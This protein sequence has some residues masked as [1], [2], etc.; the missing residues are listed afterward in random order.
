MA[1][2]QTVLYCRNYWFEINLCNY[3]LCHKVRIKWPINT[4]EQTRWHC[5]GHMI[6]VTLRRARLVLRWA[7]IHSCN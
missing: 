6:E 2:W 3:V 1:N 4:P 7:T 5:V